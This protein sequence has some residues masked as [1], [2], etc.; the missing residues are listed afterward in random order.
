MSE[1]T[2]HFEVPVGTELQTSA[3]EM[4]AKVAGLPHVEASA[5]TPE[6]FRAGLP[7]IMLVLTLGATLIQ[8][9]ASAVDALT[10]LVKSIKALAQECGLRGARVEIG[11]R[12]VPV[13]QLTPDD[14][15]A[16]LED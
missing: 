7:E 9:S 3:S 8:N 1:L 10:H 2:F 12:Q 15:K 4:Q 16:L 14:A 6:N 5:A 11:M 13:D